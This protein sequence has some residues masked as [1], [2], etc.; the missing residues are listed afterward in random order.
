MQR[1]SSQRESTMPRD[2]RM[3]RESTQKDSTVARDSV[4]RQS[5]RQGVHEESYGVTETK[6]GFKGRMSMSAAQED[7]ELLQED[8]FTDEEYQVSM[9]IF[10]KR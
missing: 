7:Q 9:A 4:Q 8:T 3:P 1:E 5:V 6:L 2:S 10:D